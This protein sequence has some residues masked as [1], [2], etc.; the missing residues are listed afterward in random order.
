MEQR[1]KAASH[2]LL[3]DVDSESVQAIIQ[4]LFDATIMQEDSAFL[5]FVGKLYNLNLEMVSMQSGVG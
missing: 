3:A 4:R 2:P 5:Y 1:H